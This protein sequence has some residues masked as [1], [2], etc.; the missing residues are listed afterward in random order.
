MWCTRA[1]SRVAAAFFSC[2]RGSAWEPL[3]EQQQQQRFKEG[4]LLIKGCVSQADKLLMAIDNKKSSVCCVCGGRRE[5]GV[6]ASGLEEWEGAR[7]LHSNTGKGCSLDLRYPCFR[8]RAY[9]SLAICSTTAFWLTGGKQRLGE[10][11]RIGIFLHFFYLL[12]DSLSSFSSLVS[13]HDFFHPSV[14]PFPPSL[15]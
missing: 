7:H 8:S 14:P 13:V 12:V 15:P 10:T 6:N 11:F 3:I 5:E 2:S 1:Q 4:R 9:V